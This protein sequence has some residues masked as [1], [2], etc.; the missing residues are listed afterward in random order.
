M[1]FYNADVSSMAFLSQQV[2]LQVSAHSG[3]PLS[4]LRLTTT[5]LTSIHPASQFSAVR[6]RVTSTKHIL[7]KRGLT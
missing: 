6:A 3:D 1:I 5:L 4:P 7:H 2:G